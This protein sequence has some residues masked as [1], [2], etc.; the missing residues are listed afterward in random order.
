M[1]EAE[2]P[3]RLNAAPRLPGFTSEMLDRARSTAATVAFAL[4]GILALGLI[5][6]VAHLIAGKDLPGPVATLGVF[7]QLVSNPFYD[8]GPNDKGVALQLMSSLGRVGMGFA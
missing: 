1:I 3:R 6:Q 4:V 8:K 5:W 2:S 7:W